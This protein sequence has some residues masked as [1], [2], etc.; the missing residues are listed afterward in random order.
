MGMHDVGV[1]SELVHTMGVQCTPYTAWTCLAGA[2]KKMMVLRWSEKLI[3]VAD[4]TKKR[5]FF[6]LYLIN[7]FM[8]I[9]GWHLNKNLKKKL[10]YN[11]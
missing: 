3:T 5:K 4:L 9:E 6:Q 10:P 1:H 2:C 7:S 11:T 8:Q